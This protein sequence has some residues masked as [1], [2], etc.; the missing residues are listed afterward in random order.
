MRKKARPATF[1]RMSAKPYDGRALSFAEQRFFE[2][3]VRRGTTDELVPPFRAHDHPRPKP[4]RYFKKRPS[5]P[6]PHTIERRRP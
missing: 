1:C 6:T 4:R 3:R 5:E 2:D